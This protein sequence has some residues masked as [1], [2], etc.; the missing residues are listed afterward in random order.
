M[1]SLAVHIL[2]PEKPDQDA[3]R[4]GHEG[5]RC[6]LRL[7]VVRRLPSAEVRPEGNWARLHHLLDGRARIDVE[8]LVGVN[9]A[10]HNALVVHDDAHVPAA[11]AQAVAH[12]ANS[13]VDPARRN[14]PPGDLGDA[15]RVS[16]VALPRQPR[17]EPIRL[18]G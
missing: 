12:G 17:G 13:L 11:L 4:R 15:L 16:L 14:V 6:P 18:A 10:E 7:Q 8:R 5:A 2:D 1:C 3:V 9:H